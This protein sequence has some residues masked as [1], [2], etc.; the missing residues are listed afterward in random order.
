M[1][2]TKRTGAKK[3]QQEAMQ[4]LQQKYKNPEAKAATCKAGDED[5]TTRYKQLVLR[6][7]STSCKAER[8]LIVKQL[9]AER[10]GELTM[11]INSNAEGGQWTKQSRYHWGRYKQA[12]EVLR[13]LTDDPIY[14]RASE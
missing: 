9:R 3:T 14:A 10:H 4:A 8:E 2:K 12:S 11:A 13:L 7:E 5:Q 6:H 1:N